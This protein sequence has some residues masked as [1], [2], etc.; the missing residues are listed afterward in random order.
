MRGWIVVTLPLVVIALLTRR[1]TSAQCEY[2]FFGPRCQFKCHCDQMSC[3]DN[4]YCT[5]GMACD[6]PYFGPACQYVDRSP[7]A[8]TDN[9]ELTD[10]NDATCVTSATTHTVTFT[11]NSSAPVVIQFVRLRVSNPDYR[12]LIQATVVGSIYGCTDQVRVEVD[13]VTSDIYCRN[14]VPVVTVRLTGDGVKYL[15]TVHQ[16]GGRNMALRQ[17]TTSSLPEPGSTADIGV[18]DENEALD[19]TTCFWAETR[20]LYTW[21]VIFSTPVKVFSVFIQNRKD[22]ILDMMEDVR[23][24]WFHNTTQL[25]QFV[26]TTPQEEYYIPYIGPT[27]MSVTSLSAWPERK[28]SRLGKFA[29]SFCE[30]NAHGDCLEG[31][32]GLDCSGTCSHCA[33]KL[34]SIEGICYECSRTNGLLTCHKL[35]LNCYKNRCDW[36]SH[37]CTEGCETGYY[38]RYCDKNSKQMESYVH[39]LN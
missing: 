20:Q 22:G 14:F 9:K 5:G 2:G 37:L 10:F 36:T 32:S 24:E 30:L 31:T 33:S 17:R 26:C 1:T 15:C 8:D 29:L 16:S 11:F 39:S 19:S 25:Y 3:D 4:G 28:N 18:D 6:P 38:G 23:V 13:H 12:D 21:S 27:N 34:C 7:L 35:C